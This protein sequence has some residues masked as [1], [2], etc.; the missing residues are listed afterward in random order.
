MRRNGVLLSQ[1][2]SERARAVRAEIGRRL[3][4]QYGAGAL[5]MPVRLTDLVRQIEQSANQSD[6]LRTG[7]PMSKADGYRKKGYTQRP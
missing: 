3:R 6:R 4:E 1:E 2:K 5:P 7:R